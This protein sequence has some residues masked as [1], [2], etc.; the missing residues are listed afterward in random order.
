MQCRQ[1]MHRRALDPFYHLSPLPSQRIEP[2]QSLY[3]PHYPPSLPLPCFLAPKGNHVQPFP[4][5]GIN[6]QVISSHLHGFQLVLQ[7][8]PLRPLLS[9]RIYCLMMRKLLIFLRCIFLSLHI[10]GSLVQKRN[11]LR[12]SLENSLGED[13][14][15]KVEL[16][17]PHNMS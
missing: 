16:G 14:Y 2:L 1:V 9:R 8:Y 3:C 15:L 11:P 5:Q 13:N 4:P 6:H 17:S 12:T 10:I 7:W